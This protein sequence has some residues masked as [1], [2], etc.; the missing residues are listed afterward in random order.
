M[1]FETFGAPHLAQKICDANH[2]QMT[3]ICN[4]RQLYVTWMTLLVHQ[5]VISSRQWSR[6]ILPRRTH[7]DGCPRA[8]NPGQPA[9]NTNLT[10]KISNVAAA[11]SDQE[12]FFTSDIPA[13]FDT[14]N[15]THPVSNIV[16]FKTIPNTHPHNSTHS[17]TNSLRVNLGVNS[18]DNFALFQTLYSLL[19]TWPTEANLTSKFGPSDATICAQSIQNLAI[20]CIHIHSVHH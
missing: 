9:N 3:H 10:L 1:T 8:S 17:Q 4:I 5:R 15:A 16:S 14:P 6:A 7:N 18:A 19:N 20:Y 13:V 11:N 2:M 12:F